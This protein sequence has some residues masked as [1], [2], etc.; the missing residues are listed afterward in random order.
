[1]PTIDNLLIRADAGPMIGAGHVMRCLALAQQWRA[2]GGRVTFACSELPEVLGDR[3]RSEGCEVVITDVAVGSPDDAAA[4]LNLARDLGAVVVADGYRFSVNYQEVVYGAARALLVLDDYGQIGTYR[5]D[6]ILDQNLGTT[7]DT[8]VDRPP[9][10]RLLLGPEYVM[11]RREFLD[12]GEDCREVDPTVR[13]IL[14]TTGGA[15]V[16]GLAG[17]ILEVLDEIPQSLNIMVLVGG[18]GSGTGMLEARVRRSHHRVRLVENAA[19]MPEFMAETDL[20]VSSAGS[21]VWELAYLGVPAVLGVVAENQRV[22]A[23]TLERFGAA[24]AFDG[25]SPSAAE[26]LRTIIALLFDDYP[27]RSAMSETAQGLVDGK[28]AVRVVSGILATANRRYP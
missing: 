11:L 15:D 21:T 27:R 13:N 8:Y 28:G 4:T 22:G 14:V 7:E 23:S 5:A 20:A 16:G 26:E 9:D 2:E 1:M 19:N 6:I 17:T 3:L 25:T 12:A 24:V 18:A 10:C